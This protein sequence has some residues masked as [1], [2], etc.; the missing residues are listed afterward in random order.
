[1][2]DYSYILCYDKNIIDNAK[3]T[4]KM[5]KEPFFVKGVWSKS[6]NRKK[7]AKKMNLMYPNSCRHHL[8][9]LVII[10]FKIWMLS[11]HMTSY[12]GDKDWTIIFFCVNVTPSS[13]DGSGRGS[14]RP[15]GLLKP[16]IIYK[17][18]SWKKY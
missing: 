11:A 4:S 10:Y 14:P 6:L 17:Y 16:C 18:F 1:M 7:L 2:L 13:L 3:K 9:I 8:G 15:P 5:F 12:I